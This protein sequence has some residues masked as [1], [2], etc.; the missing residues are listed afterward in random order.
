MPKAWSGRGARVRPPPHSW[1]SLHSAL[2][3]RAQPVH[4]TCTTLKVTSTGASSCARRDEVT[5]AHAQGIQNLGFMDK[6][7]V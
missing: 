6:K 2:W 5:D 3:L 4:A 7:L 1:H